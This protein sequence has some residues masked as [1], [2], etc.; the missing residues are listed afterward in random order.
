MEA[1]NGV[2]V[3]WLHHSQR[4]HNHRPKASRA[5]R[6][7]EDTAK[8][9]N[10]PEAP[11]SP[12]PNSSSPSLTIPSTKSSTA[13]ASSP[14]SS[15][16]SPHLPTHMHRPHLA[17]RPSTEKQ[18]TATTTSAPAKPAENGTPP[19]PSP[20]GRRNS[21]LTGLTSKFSSSPSHQSPPQAS[22]PA[23]GKPAQDRPKATPG[24][25]PPGRRASL[26]EA[27]PPPKDESIPY[28][29]AAPKPSHSSSFLQSALRRLSSSSGQ[30]PGMTK[31]V[32]KGG[33]C[34]RRVMNVDRERDRCKI[35]ELDQAKLRRVAFCV[36][37][38][39]AGGPRYSEEDGSEKLPKKHKDKEKRLKEKGEG[40]ALKHP[41]SVQEDKDKEGQIKVDGETVETPD[42]PK[43]DGVDDE[44]K[45]ESQADEGKKEPTKKKEKKKRSEEERK[46]RKEKK[47][48]HDE[49]NGSIPMENVMSCEEGTP[50]TTP[51]GAS[52]PKCQDRPTTDPLRIYRRCCQL[53]ETPVLKKI[54]EQLSQSPQPGSTP[55]V[56]NALDLSSYWMQ[57]ADV[58]TL[59][60]W[61]AVVPIK[62]LMLENCGLGDE[63]VRLILAGLLAARP[64]NAPR[65]HST[66]KRSVGTKD[67]DGGKPYAHE[68]GRHGVIEKLV[69]KNN[70]KIGPEGWKH[71]SLFLHLSRSIKAVDLSMNPFPQDLTRSTTK[72][73]M[74]SEESLNS[75]TGSSL[76]SR[77]I[78]ER[79]AGGQLEELVMSECDLSSQD[80]ISIVDGVSKIGLKRLGLASNNIDKESL[81]HVA[82]Y[83][84]SGRCEG[85][86]LGG[87]D[88]QDHVEILANSMDEN[89]P[90]WALSLADCNLSP[91]SLSTLFPTL[92]SLPSCRFIDLSHNR[93][94][95]ESEPNALGLCRKYLPR[96]KTIKRFHL[97]DVGLTAEHAVALAEI[98][99][100]CKT[101]AHL[102]ILENPKITVLADAKD[103]AA[104]EEACALYASLMAAV[105]VSQSIICIDVDV[106]SPESS[107]IVK[108]LAKQ[109]VAYS[110][111]NMEQ[112]A[113]AEVGGKPDSQGEENYV[114]PDVLMHLVGHDE[115]YPEH[116][117][118]EEPAPDTDYLI[119]GTG[120]VKALSICLGSTAYDSRRQ[121]RDQSASAS[122]TATPRAVPLSTADY[123]KAKPKVVSKNLLASARKIRSRL[124]PALA[125]EAKAEDEMNYRRLCFLDQTL[126]RIIRRFE[127]EYPECRLSPPDPI[128]IPPHLDIADSVS[129]GSSP[130]SSSLH[131]ATSDA[132]H[133][134]DATSPTS[135]DEDSLIRSWTGSLVRPPSD[136]SLASKAL[137]DEEGRMHRFGQQFRRDMVRTPTPTPSTAD[138][139]SAVSETPGETTG[140]QVTHMDSLRE[141]VASMPGDEL[142][143][144]YDEL[145]VGGLMDDLGANLQELT[146]LSQEDPEAFEAFRVSQLTAMLNVEMSKAVQTNHTAP[147]GV[148]ASS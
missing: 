99:P 111:R 29:P 138:S 43:P 8:A 4:D 141:K 146:V 124:Q 9:P 68:A 65:R 69:L 41:E 113:V 12:S 106:P 127:D 1:I 66:T 76:I 64:P 25:P 139:N 126:E 75:L 91:S 136:V 79:F 116:L 26:S 44:A 2:D 110:L 48:R 36:D 147:L 74:K 122:G 118:M 61:L 17:R 104:M 28:T 49:A 100:E 6:A 67:T 30:L 33:I 94:L 54:T 123:E 22:P 134:T 82:G 130:D 56:V 95:F 27:T 148:E 77:A 50:G 57:L 59:S 31:G 45:Q 137:S 135:D 83:L 19:P 15:P 71:I 60:D 58:V 142:R 85:L 144:K 18:A 14:K 89:T 128:A 117:D 107:E 87:N 47:R 51:P 133:F 98:L 132:F 129:V 34:E 5:Q 108:A 120:V 10:A 131:S 86:D 115:Q 72:E 78:A 38:E 11:S 35:S 121:S 112:G 21:W 46:E 125:R 101:L 145:G 92:V 93:K 13:N 42:K 37:V 81:E 53:R 55:G 105:R 143:R 32:G 96:L 52:T 97:A 80:V 103:E 16:T 90:L 140:G 84:K 24:Y 39:I 102:S 62:K 70:P 119:G 114:L 3:S 88:L 20:S 109:V 73:S 23:N 7:P 40:E 63:G